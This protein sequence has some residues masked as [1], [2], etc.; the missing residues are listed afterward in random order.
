MTVGVAEQLE[1]ILQYIVWAYKRIGSYLTTSPTKTKK[2][3]KF[4]KFETS[5]S[6]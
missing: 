3:R 5:K 2:T 6:P 4:K 1:T